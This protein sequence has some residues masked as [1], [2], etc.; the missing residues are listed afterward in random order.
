MNITEQLLTLRDEKYA[1]FQIKLTPGL[2]RDN[3][4]GVRVPEIRKL[5]KSYIREEE[6]T[7]FLNTLPHRYYDENML[8]GILISEMKD[9]EE[10]IKYVEAFLPYVD[11]WAVCDSMSPRIFKK[12]RPE[13]LEIIKKWM[14][15]GH[16][17]TCRFGIDMLMTHYLDE[18]FRPEYLKYPSEIQTDEYYINMMI[19]WYYATALAKQWEDSVVYIEN[20]ILSKWVHNKTIQKAV[21]SYRVSNEH[22]DYLKSM[23]IR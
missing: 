6:S 4:I 13:L 23:K 16:T 18:D 11:N 3:L 20:N 1:E 9:F 22:K 7:V 19:S 17:Y 2:T 5:A 14:L 10:C 12:H 21:E 8:H 15:S